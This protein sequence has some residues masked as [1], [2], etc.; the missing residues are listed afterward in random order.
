MSKRA[1]M[2]HLIHVQ[3]FLPL[4]GQTLSGPGVHTPVLV[5]YKNNIGIPFGVEEK[6]GY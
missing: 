4:G 5:Y 1:D 6:H 2:K 3:V